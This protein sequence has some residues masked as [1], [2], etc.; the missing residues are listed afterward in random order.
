MVSDFSELMQ[1]I[2]TFRDE[3]NWKQFQPSMIQT[4]GQIGKSRLHCREREYS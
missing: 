3:R 2:K 1:R 4:A